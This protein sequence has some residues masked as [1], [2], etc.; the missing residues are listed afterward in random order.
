[1]SVPFP[2]EEN[3]HMMRYA[4]SRRRPNFSKDP[5]IVRFQGR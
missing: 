3:R 2:L 4:D 1:M 5:A